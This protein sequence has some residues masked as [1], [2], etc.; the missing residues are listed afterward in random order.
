MAGQRSRGFT[1]VELLVVITIIGVLIALLLPA[2][3]AAREAARKMQCG[4]NLKQLALGGLSHE[5]A[6][7]YVPT[8]GWG[9]T[10]VGDPD[11]GFGL[12]QPGG[13]IYNILPFIEEDSIR[14]MGS[15]LPDT[16]K[17]TVAKTMIGMPI[18]TLNCPSRRSPVAI[19]YPTTLPD[20]INAD[21]PGVIAH[22]DYAINGGSS[23]THS[24]GGPDSLSTAMT[25]SY[26]WWS[27]IAG[28]TC[29]GQRRGAI[30]QTDRLQ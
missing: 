21:R 27:S 1:L 10:W 22:A 28:N 8:T 23:R 12:K 20:M 7:G 25:P 14:Q 9:M 18:A 11:R 6:Y 13:W 26:D 19:S 16:Q 3:Q 15:G 29:I 17:H 24:Q 5:S 4:N 2:V 30:S